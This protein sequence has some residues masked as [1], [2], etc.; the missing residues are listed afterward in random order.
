MSYL[1]AKVETVNAVDADFK[2]NGKKVQRFETSNTPFDDLESA[3]AEIQRLAP[4]EFAKGI[5]RLV[6]LTEIEQALAPKVD[7]EPI[8][9]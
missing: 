2:H 1:V 6:I 8:K 3:R 5:E 7:I 4:R 9:L